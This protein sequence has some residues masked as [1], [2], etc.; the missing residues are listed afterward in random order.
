MTKI[1][2]NVAEYYVKHFQQNKRKTKY[3]ID[4]LSYAKPP[5]KPKLET[6]KVA[7]TNESPA[8]VNDKRV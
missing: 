3:A 1:Q 6:M 8:Q 5:D 2:K 7:S 4:L